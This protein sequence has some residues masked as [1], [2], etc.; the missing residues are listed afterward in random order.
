MQDIPYKSLCQAPVFKPP[1]GGPRG[2]GGE[3]ESGRGNQR[4]MG[5]RSWG[6]REEESVRRKVEGRSEGKSCR[7]G[8]RQQLIS[9]RSQALRELVFASVFAGVGQKEK[10]RRGKKERSPVI[11]KGE[12]E[13]RYR[14][15][16]VNLKRGEAN[17]RKIQTDCGGRSHLQVVY[18]DPT[19]APLQD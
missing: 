1:G 5:D 17:G 13:G 7:F 15:V 4:A 11:G 10:S 14:D 6:S 12:A 8:S 3:C 9:E 18:Q 2:P 19:P 16:P